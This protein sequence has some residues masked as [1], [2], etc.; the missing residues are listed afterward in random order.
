MT[1]TPKAVIDKPSDFLYVGDEIELALNHG[2]TALGIE[3]NTQQHFF[4]ISVDSK[5]FES[6]HNIRIGLKDE[7]AR[8]MLKAFDA[9]AESRGYFKVKAW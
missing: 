1:Y 8:E 4:T 5:P 6:V 7:V 2:D 9:L 3:V